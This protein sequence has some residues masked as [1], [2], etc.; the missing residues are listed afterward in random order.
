[1]PQVSTMVGSHRA[2]RGGYILSDVISQVFTEV[3]HHG[4]WPPLPQDKQVSLWQESHVCDSPSGLNE[5]LQFKY[6]KQLVSKAI[7]C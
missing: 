4:G 6:T 7:R 2:P 1:M 3:T 5:H